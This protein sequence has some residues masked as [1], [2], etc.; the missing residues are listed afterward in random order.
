MEGNHIEV[1]SG[2]NLFQWM[3]DQKLR[4]SKTCRVVINPALL[5]PPKPDSELQ[6]LMQ[7]KEKELR[8]GKKRVKIFRCGAAMVTKIVRK[9]LTKYI[10]H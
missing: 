10:M 2:G 3:E 1:V 6:K 5:C 7:A 9:T 4:K 8:A